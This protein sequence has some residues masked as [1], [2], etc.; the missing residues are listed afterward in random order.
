MAKAKASLKEGLDKSAN[1]KGFTG[2]ARHRYI[3]GAIR[4]MEKRGT[5]TAKKRVAASAH[6][7]TPRPVHRAPEPPPKPRVKLVLVVK[8]NKEATAKVAAREAKF[9]RKGYPI[10]SV[11]DAN[12]KMHG[13][14]TYSKKKSAEQ[15]ANSAMF[16]HNHP[17]GEHTRNSF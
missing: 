11:Y 5:I 10:Y 17:K 16:A 14:G 4:N 7:P 8:V 13:S 3:G 15:E 6:K 1:K 12:G 9:N 2:A